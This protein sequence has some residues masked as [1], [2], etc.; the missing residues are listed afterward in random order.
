[1]SS[2]LLIVA[3][4]LIE[5]VQLAKSLE[6]IALFLH[7]AVFCCQRIDL[8]LMFFVLCPEL[9]KRLEVVAHI[10]E[11]SSDLIDSLLKR[12]HG[13]VGENFKGTAHLIG[14]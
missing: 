1:M 6:L 10:A 5:L 11:P 4:V 7:F 9:L 8:L 12:D 2:S 14:K 13:V 3:V